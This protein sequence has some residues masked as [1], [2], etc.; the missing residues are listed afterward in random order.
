LPVKL[1]ARVLKAPLAFSIYCGLARSF[2]R[3]AQAIL[4]SASLPNL[5]PKRITSRWTKVQY[6]LVDKPYPLLQLLK[7]KFLDFA[8][9]EK[10]FPQ[11]HRHGCH[12][13]LVIAKQP[14]FNNI[15][16]RLSY[17]V[18]II[19]VPSTPNGARNHDPRK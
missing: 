13:I 6:F 3:I 9:R 11:N 12:Q 8:L 18:S 2:Y 16:L 5:G 1:I 10:P 7:Y 17:S 4:G 14:E 19:M 15:N